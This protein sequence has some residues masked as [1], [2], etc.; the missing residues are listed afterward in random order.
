MLKLFIFQTQFVL[1]L[2]YCAL[3]H[4]SPKCQ[5]AAGFTY[6]ISFNIIVFL[7][8]FVNFYSKSYK[9]P[10]DTLTQKEN[11][12]QNGHYTI[13]GKTHKGNGINPE[14][15]TNGSKVPYEMNNIG[16]IK[17]GNGLTR[18]PLKESI[19]GPDFNFSNIE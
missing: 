6:F 10:K 11:I 19:Y 8:L 18:R 3:T 14:F 2:V 5:Y 4:F 17:N 16:D 13:N 7:L 12:H 15:S 9:R 1:M